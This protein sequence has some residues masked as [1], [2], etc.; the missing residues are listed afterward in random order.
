MQCYTLY[1]KLYVLSLYISF[2]HDYYTILSWLNDRRQAPARFI[3]SGF[4]DET[5]K[6]KCSLIVHPSRS[7]VSALESSVYYIG[8]HTAFEQPDE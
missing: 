5:F 7:I 2:E 4:T 1:S 8:E 6:S 3:L